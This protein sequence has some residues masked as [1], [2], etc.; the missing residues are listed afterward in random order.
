MRKISANGVDGHAIRPTL[1]Q[2]APTTRSDEI[3]F[4]DGANGSDSR[5]TAM[6]PEIYASQAPSEI[7]ITT[8]ERSF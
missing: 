3:I 8:Y 7:L 5:T 4:R 6:L 1:A 2:A